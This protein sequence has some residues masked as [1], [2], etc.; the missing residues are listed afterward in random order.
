MNSHQR[1]WST[2]YRRLTGKPRAKGV[3]GAIII[4]AGFKE[5]GGEGQHPQETVKGIAR[6][7][8]GIAL[9]GPNC[10]GSSIPIPT[11]RMNASFAKKMPAQAIS[12]G[13]PASEQPWNTP[14]G[15]GPVPPG[16]QHGVSA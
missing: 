10:L 5:V 3:K 9:I 1:S 15:A 4:S 16:H 6:R 13:F 12:S 8:Y 2:S 7:R 11:V 14:R